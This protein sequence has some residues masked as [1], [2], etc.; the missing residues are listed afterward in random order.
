VHDPELDPEVA[1]Q[2]A[3]ALS[4][5]AELLASDGPDSPEARRFYSLHR[6]LPQFA[7]LADESNRLERVFRGHGRTSE[8]VAATPSMG[9]KPGRRLLRFAG[10]VAAAALLVAAG[11]ALVH[12]D[13][14]A[15]DNQLQLQSVQRE[16]HQLRAVQEEALRERPVTTPPEILNECAS[17]RQEI[18][19]LQALQEETRQTILATVSPW[20]PDLPPFQETVETPDPEPLAPPPP[21]PISAG[22]VES[23]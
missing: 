18:R 1:D 20:S 19:R 10:A 11:F 4:R 6:D 2:V 16:L 9:T 13:R 12:L 15:R 5:Y 7:E 17:L 21:A 14:T 8:T 22:R 23:D 3:E